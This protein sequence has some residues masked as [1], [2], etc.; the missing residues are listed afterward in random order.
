MID[1]MEV[2]QSQ[3]PVGNTVVIHVDTGNDWGVLSLEIDDAGRPVKIHPPLSRLG[4]SNN[5]TVDPEELSDDVRMLVD[6]LATYFSS[7]QT[8]PERPLPD[9]TILRWLAAAGIASEFMQRALIALY[10]TNAGDTI[11]YSDLARLAGNP[12]A[13]R[14]AAS[15]CS[16]NPFPILIPCQRVLPLAGIDHWRRSGASDENHCSVGRYAGDAYGSSYKIR[17][18]N[19]EKRAE[20]TSQV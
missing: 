2:L 11:S 16:R 17:L 10:A 5:S 7:D 19:H 3:D 18:L 20:S 8:I 6:F 4:Q 12:K 1:T 13:V 9:A 15:A 14:A